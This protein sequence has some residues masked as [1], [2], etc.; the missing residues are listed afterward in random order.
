[1]VA[2][3]LAED[4]RVAAG[5]AAIRSRQWYEAHELLEIPWR[6]EQDL[7][8]KATLQGLIHGAVALEHL[9]RGNPRGAWGQLEK[10]RA[11]LQAECSQVEG[12][13]PRRW[14]EALLTFSKRIELEERSRR[15]V[16]RRSLEGLPSLPPEEDWPL[17]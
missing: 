17:P 14:L 6:E 2:T 3:P 11:R 12:A 4:P 5:L 8:R 9:R 16:A 1:M 15:Q 13:D 7:V 10:A